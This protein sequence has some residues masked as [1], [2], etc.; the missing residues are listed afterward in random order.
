MLKQILRNFVYGAVFAL[1][2]ASVGM[3]V[4]NNPI[5]QFTAPSGS[6][7]AQNPTILG[8]LNA[9]INSINSSIGT[10]LTLN[11]STPEQGE[12]ALSAT[13]AFSANG[14][15]AVAAIGSTGVAG[16]N[17]VLHEWMAVIDEGGSLG[18]IPV[19]Y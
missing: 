15:V 4:A 12:V 3:A 2:L 6:N 5:A 10:W 7:P 8:D 18:Y 19:Y 16:T 13:N 14:T 9:L 1:G 11:N 17:G